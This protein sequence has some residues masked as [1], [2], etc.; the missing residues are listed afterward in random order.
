MCRSDSPTVVL[1]HGAFADASGFARVIHELIARGLDVMAP[2]VP[3]RSLPGD[4]AHIASIVRGIRTGRPGRA[5]LRR[6]RHHRRRCE[7]NV[8]ALVCLAG[9]ALEEGESLRELQGGF[10]DSGLASAPVH[11]PFPIEGSTTPGH[12]RVGRIDTFP[13]ISDGDD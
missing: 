2:A 1:V 13:S 12:R 6:R 9:H 3:D 5:L 11:T 4:S 8:Q 10:P 7:D